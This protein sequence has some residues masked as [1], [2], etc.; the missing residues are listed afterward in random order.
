MAWIKIID[1]KEARDDLE[2]VYQEI[3]GARG[4]L[5]N[6][7]RVHSLNPRAMK[8]HMD[9]YRSIMF[10]E[11]KM[12]RS[13]REAIAVVVSSA[14]GCEYCINHHAEALRAY[15]DNERVESLIQDYRKAKL[16]DCE[17]AAMHYASKLTLTPGKMTQED[18]HA[19]REA[20]FAD[21]EIL[22]INLVV[23]YFNFVNRIASGL[24]AEFTE[25]EVSGYK[26]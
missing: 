3:T 14:N 23:S 19:L 6:I 15:W 17:S 22:N 25:D 11:V 4:K 1:E 5:S 7:M 10:G 16:S 8:S 12:S 2:K 24:G 20:G 9:L 21:E 18:I 26:Y 13:L